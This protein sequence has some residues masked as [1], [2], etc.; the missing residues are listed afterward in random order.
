M[1]LTERILRRDWP[2][3]PIARLG[4]SASGVEDP[5]GERIDDPVGE[6]IDDPRPSPPRNA[7]RASPRNSRAVGRSSAVAGASGTSRV[8]WGS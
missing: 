4:S 7:R 3:I 5:V 1:T 2:V 6:R 8:F